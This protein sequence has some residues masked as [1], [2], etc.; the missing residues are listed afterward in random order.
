MQKMTLRLGLG[1]V[2]CALSAV[3][4]CGSSDPPVMMMEASLNQ[5]IVGTWNS[6][7]CEL[8]IAIP[9]AP[10]TPYYKRTYKFTETDWSYAF[11]VYFDANCALKALTMDAKGTYTIGAMVSAPAGANEMNFNYAERGMTAYLSQATQLLS[12][13]SCGG[14]SAWTVGMRVDISTNGCGTIV[15]SNTACPKEFDVISL[16]GTNLFLGQRPMSASGLC[17]TRPTTLATTALV[18]P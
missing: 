11:D 16:T 8:G 2:T 6:A 1:L 3:A 17:S 18:K 4:G 7:S 14:T 12:G 10:V 13:L 15:P 5:K 9:G